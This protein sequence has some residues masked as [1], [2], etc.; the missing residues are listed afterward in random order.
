[1]KN[2]DSQT[3]SEWT[4][5]K[6]LNWTSGYFDEHS[7]ESPR[8][9]AEILLA[10][11]LDLKRID[12]YLKY[13]QPLTDGELS[14][15][16]ALIKRRV[17]NE[18]VAYI[19]GSKEFWSLDIRVTRDVLIPRPETECLV[20]NALTLLNKTVN[21]KPKRILELGTGSGAVVLALAA[22]RAGHSY[23]ASDS[24]INALRVARKNAESHLLDS[25]IR[26][27]CAEWFDSLS[28]NPGFDL[29]ISNPPYIVSAE[30]SHLQPEIHEYEP[31]TAL[32]GDGDGLGCLK[33]I[34]RQA[35]SFLRPHGY[36]ILEIGHD[37]KN[38]VQRLAEQHGRYVDIEFFK[39]YSGIDR[40][41]R[42]RKR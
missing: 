39:D 35:D 27:F 28:N 42:M 7:V 5:L 10:Y 30:I 15:Y 12:L 26:F 22:N 41:V 16:K 8:A 19:T 11:A 31:W 38:M 29:V 18:P 4:I 23:F 20:E 40:I 25:R 14:R 37:Q 32:D 36:L 13:D 33:E 2:P 17:K 34:I 24:S 9:S 3:G 1:M 6:L 21:R